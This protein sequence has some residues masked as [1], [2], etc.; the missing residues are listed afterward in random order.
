MTIFFVFSIRLNAS[1]IV[2]IFVFACLTFSCKHV[3]YHP[4]HL[5]LGDF[6]DVH[7]YDGA[8]VEPEPIKVAE[9]NQLFVFVRLNF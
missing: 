5:A 7:N 4:M 1:L 3:F 8:E 2:L 9:G 6:E